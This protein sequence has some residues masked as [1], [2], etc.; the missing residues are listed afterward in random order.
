MKKSILAV[1][2]SMFLVSAAIASEID[3]LTQKLVEKNV[4]EAGEAQQI[5]A[6]TRD[7]IAKNL[8]LGK[9]ENVPGWAQ[10]IK[11]SGYSQLSFT[12]DQSKAGKNAFTVKRARIA[13]TATPNDFMTFKIQPDFASIATPQAVSTTTTTISSKSVLQTASVTAADVG[14]RE[15]WID[16]IFDKNLAT[17]RL[18]QYHQPFGFENCYSSSRKKV[19]DTPKYMSSV[20]TGDYDYGVQL[21]GN[22]PGANKKLLMWR[23]A[24]MNGTTSGSETDSRKDYGMRFTSSVTKDIELGLSSYFRSVN[25]GDLYSMSANAYLKYEAK[26]L[27]GLAPIPTFLTA[28]FVGG[29]G[30]NGT[31]DVLDAIFTLEIKPF[32]LLMPVLEGVSPVLRVEQWDPNQHK[33]GDEIKYYTI[34][35]NCYVDKYVR[36]L[37]DYRMTDDTN[38]TNNNTTTK[39]NVMLQVKY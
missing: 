36:L 14:F 9:A 10:Y 20:I 5:L 23:I 7:E 29:K 21:W 6:D 4:L 27:L 12:D 11:W 39:M 16:L 22:L 19:F 31:T 1:T 38:T 26:T 8:A 35:V 15:I 28:E 13:L 18:G 17:A 30:S 25:S 2:I 24:V 3:I 34:G 33:N 32:G 37:A